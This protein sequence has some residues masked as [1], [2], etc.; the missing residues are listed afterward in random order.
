[1]TALQVTDDYHGES[2]SPPLT[3]S[4]GAGGVPAIAA[5]PAAAATQG[6]RQHHTLIGAASCAAVAATGTTGR[7][8]RMTRIL[9]VTV[10]IALAVAHAGPVGLRSLT[11][12]LPLFTNLAVKPGFRLYL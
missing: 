11:H 12:T 8:G 4:S 10:Y 1:V 9:G 7:S 5:A 2:L 3:V 6:T